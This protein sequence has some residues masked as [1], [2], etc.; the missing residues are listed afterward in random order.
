MFTNYRILKFLNGILLVVVSQ[1][2]RPSSYSLDCNTKPM[3]GNLSCKT[4]KE[5]LYKE[6]NDLTCSGLGGRDA[7]NA[8]DIVH[9]QECWLGTRHGSMKDKNDNANCLLGSCHCQGTNIW[10]I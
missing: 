10:L 6:E 3:V 7:A 4:N 2:S 9:G 1:L 5:C 8:C